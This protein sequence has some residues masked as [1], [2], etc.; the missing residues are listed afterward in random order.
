MMTMPVTAVELQ[1]L[2]EQRNLY[3]WYAAANGTEPHDGYALKREGDKWIV[4]RYGLAAIPNERAFV[5][6]QEAVK[7]LLERLRKDGFADYLKDL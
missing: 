1:K 6:E 5:D 7:D 4:Y 3:P 2:L